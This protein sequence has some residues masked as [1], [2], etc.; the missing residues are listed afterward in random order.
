MIDVIAAIA[1]WFQLAANLTLLGSCIFLAIA[2]TGKRAY[3]DPW[4]E[5]LERLF[6]WLAISIP[7]GLIVILT[8]TITQATGNPDNLWQQ[9][10]WLGFINDTRVGQI[11]VWRISL[12]TLLL[13][14]VIYLRKSPRARWRY[15]LGAV[16]A[17]L[18]LVAGSLTSHSATEELSLSIITPFA[19]HLIL[20]GVWFGA[21]P[22]FLLLVYEN[23][24]SDKNKRITISEFETLRRFSAVALPAMLL[25]V[26]TGFIVAD[27]MFDGYYA[28]SVATSYGWLLSIK[29]LILAVILFIAARVRAHWLPLLAN[30]ATAADADAGRAGVKKWVRIEFILALL[31]LLLATVIASTT[32]V[33]YALIENWPYP[34]R[35]SINA[36]WNQPNVATQVWIGAF[37]LILAAGA[38]L[39]GKFRHWKY[40]RLIGIPTV[41]LV[42]GLAVAL[43]P[44][45]IQAYPETYRRPPVPFDA[46]SVANGAALYAQHCVEC[47]GFQGM[48]NGIKS[49]TLSTKLP[50]LLTEPHTVE[51]TPGDFYHW[52]SYGMINTDMPGFADKLS[53]ED[54]WDLVNYVHAL[55]R[56]YQARILAPEIIPN[57]AYVK[58]P[59]FSYAENNGSSGTLQDFRNH[60]TVLL[61]IF[62]WPQSRD[63]L[64][65]LKQA[66]NQL[67]EQNVALLA[68]PAKELSDDEIVQI[69][70]EL[71]FP[72]VTQSAAEIV[73]SYALSRRTISHPD[74][75][76]RG[77]NPDHMEFLIDRNGYMRARWI[78]A[79]DQSGWSD[80]ATLR[81]QIGLLNREKMVIPYPEDYIR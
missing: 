71:P 70:T 37:I 47:H 39:L 35:F 36:T 34:F 12:A 17:A 23:N 32:P 30:S 68:V 50:D 74:I 45:T 59:V 75:I 18:P 64:E 66:Y 20:A 9:D 10:T 29:I 2:D 60:K 26:V 57:K 25:I 6:P 41:L 8:A 33:K 61:V 44:L 76:G 48:G 55:S 81:Q 63:R 49:R 38:I 51:H 27:R 16:I 19:L 58:P 77:G 79:V 40:R 21:L 24:K 15:L 67:S 31:L 11:W 46:T 7:M 22:A 56:G 73:T 65:Q 42:S 54:R 53:D 3:L 13:F 69:T 72:V 5:K 14:I 62:S 52:I 4:I 43:P 28:A 80:I 1:R 78:P